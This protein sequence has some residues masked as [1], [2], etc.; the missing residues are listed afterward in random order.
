VKSTIED[1]G[2]N[3]RDVRHIGHQVYE[4]MTDYYV[5]HRGT[6]RERML[7]KY[8]AFL[9]N[10]LYRSLLK[11]KDVSRKEIIDYIVIK[12]SANTQT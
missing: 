11:M 7:K 8:P 9:E 4:P 1:N 12:A 5:L 3:I 6:L 2:F 10:I